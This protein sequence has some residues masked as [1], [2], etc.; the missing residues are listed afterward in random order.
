VALGLP[1]AFKKSRAD[2]TELRESSLQHVSTWTRF[3]RRAMTFAD[4]LLTTY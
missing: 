4:S 3:P 1:Q 2:V